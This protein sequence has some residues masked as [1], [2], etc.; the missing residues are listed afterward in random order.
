M[1]CPRPPSIGRP[2]EW[3][4]RV[5][6]D[7]V[8]ALKAALDAHL[9]GTTEHFQHEHRIRHEDGTYRRFLCRGLAA[10]G[11]SRRR[12]RIAGSLTDTTE[13][14][15]AQE[16]LRSVGFRDPLTGLCNRAVFVEGLG[17]RLDEFKRR[18]AAATGSPCS[19]WTST[20]SRSST[21][22]SVTWSATS[23]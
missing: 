1:A 4:D 6:A 22:A 13:H 12:G 5:H 21:T 19:I 11:A 18:T 10:R 17:Q 15:I 16:R 7:D 14:G 20:A 9:A 3:F 2:E 8:V 23:C